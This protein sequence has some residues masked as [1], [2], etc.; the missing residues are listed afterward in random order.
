MND[1]FSVII[2][3]WNKAVDSTTDFFTGIFGGKPKPSQSKT[4]PP[5]KPEPDTKPQ[6][7]KNTPAPPADDGM[8]TVYMWGSIISAIVVG[9]ACCCLCVGSIAYVTYEG[10]R[11]F[12]APGDGLA[13]AGVEKKRSTPIV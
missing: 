3:L 8:Q 12:G 6:Q 11:L 7:K 1:P 9:L 2:W 4:T 10:S 13:Q 5:K